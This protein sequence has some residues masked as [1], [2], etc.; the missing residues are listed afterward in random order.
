MPA[1]FPAWDRVYAFWRRWRDQGL[2][3]E[4]HDRL[5]QIGARLMVDALAKLKGGTMRLVPQSDEG[6]T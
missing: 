2:I 4:L 3:G 1:D 5:M 6:V